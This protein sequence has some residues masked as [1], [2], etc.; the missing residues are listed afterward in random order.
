MSKLLLSNVSPYQLKVHLLRLALVVYIKV[1]HST[2][3]SV[4]I[5]RQSG[6]RDSRI[7]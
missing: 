3:V 5:P 1:L 7:I 6:Y 4:V 2:L